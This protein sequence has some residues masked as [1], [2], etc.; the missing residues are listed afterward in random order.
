MTIWARMNPTL[1]RLL[2][3]ILILLTPIGPQGPRDSF[4]LQVFPGDDSSEYEDDELEEYVDDEDYYYEDEP[5][6]KEEVSDAEDSGGE[7]TQSSESS[8]EDIELY[9]EPYEPKDEDLNDFLL[10]EEIGDLP[11]IEAQVFDVELSDWSSNQRVYLFEDLDALA[12][13]PGR[14]ILVRR[15]DQNVLAFRV[16]RSYGDRQQ[17]AAAV[18]RIYE[19]GAVEIGDRLTGIY[20]IRDLSDSF[21]DVEGF[22]DELN[23][24]EDAEG[25]AISEGE[26]ESYPD[27]EDEDV[28]EEP[29]PR[30]LPELP[31]VMAYDPDLDAGSSPPPLGAVDS[32]TQDIDLASDFNPYAVDEIRP[33][34]TDR[35]W[36]SANIGFFKNSTSNDQQNGMYSG[37]GL[38]Y[39]YMV[40]RQVLV[41]TP[42]VQDSF[43]AEIGLANYTVA[44]FED[45]TDS[46]SVLPIHATLRYNLLLQE[47][48]SA[49]LYGGILKNQV[50]SSVEGT[51]QAESSLSSFLPALGAGLMFRIGPKWHIR[52]DVGMDLIGGGLVLRF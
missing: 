24:V 11:D 13:P 28:A 22:E 2:I 37:A 44:N 36:L 38:R 40:G 33:F 23:E 35:H 30:D 16:I 51:A 7:N 27:I 34:D 43:A 29:E 9:D 4:A 46:Y 52:A 10:T 32:E 45:E 41:D 31:S 14:I 20:K 12:P 49:F 47:D 19:L 50:L 18:V 42:L 48:L 3:T 17:F 25:I 26:E 6:D 5:A 15:D 21:D 8:L 39:A 1:I